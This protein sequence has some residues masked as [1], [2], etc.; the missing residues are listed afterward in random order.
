[1]NNKNSL[2]YPTIDLFLYDL[3]AG[4]GQDEEQ[5]QSNREQFWQKIYNGNQLNSHLLE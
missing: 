1:M 2:I 5:I 3:K 4:L